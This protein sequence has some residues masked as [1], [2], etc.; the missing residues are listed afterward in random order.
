MITFA[1]RKQLRQIFHFDKSEG[2]GLLVLAEEFGGTADGECGSPCR[3]AQARG[4]QG[5]EWR[6][7]QGS[8][9]Q[10]GD[11]VIGDPGQHI[12]K[13]GPGNQSGPG[14]ALGSSVRLAATLR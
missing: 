8:S 12:G 5:I 1:L 3:H 4:R 6:Q 13:L 10:V 9:A 14:Q 11:F 7:I 2:D